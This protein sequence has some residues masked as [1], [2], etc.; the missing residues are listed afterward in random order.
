MLSLGSQSH[1]KFEKRE[2]KNKKEEKEEGRGEKEGEE[3]ENM[4]NI[5]YLMLIH[6]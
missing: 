5:K 3:R 2:R 4:V 6:Q 1:L